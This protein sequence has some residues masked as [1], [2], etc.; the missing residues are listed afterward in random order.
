MLNCPLAGVLA[1]EVLDA[2]A[3]WRA[4]ARYI[5]DPAF[6]QPAPQVQDVDLRL[7]QHCTEPEINDVSFVGVVAGTASAGYDLWVGGGLSTNPMFAQRLG[8]FVRPDRVTEVWAGCA[9][10]LPRLRLPA[11]SATAPASSS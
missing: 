3:S 4:V 6:S 11:A 5:G 1:D 8:V 10:D 7:R 2:T 9:V